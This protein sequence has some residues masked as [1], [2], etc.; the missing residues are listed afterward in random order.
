[1]LNRLHLADDSTL[2]FLYH[3]ISKSY[4][5]ISLLANYNEAYATPMYTLNIWSKLVRQIEELNYML[6]WN[7]QDPQAEV[8]IIESFEPVLSDFTTYLIKINNMIQTLAANQAMY[9]LDI[10]YNRLIKHKINITQRIL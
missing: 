6:D 9:Y 3:F 8:N 1:M 2:E 7:I 5:N 10:V 4:D